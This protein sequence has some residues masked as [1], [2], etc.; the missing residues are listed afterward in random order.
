MEIDRHVG[1]LYQLYN[2]IK[3]FIFMQQLKEFHPMD[4]FKKSKCG[5][6]KIKVYLI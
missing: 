6:K 4:Q 3:L 5:N 2:S 1:C